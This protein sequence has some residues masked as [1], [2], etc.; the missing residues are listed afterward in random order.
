MAS[1]LLLYSGNLN[2]VNKDGTE[3]ENTLSIVCSSDLNNLARQWAGDFSA[4]HPEIKIEIITADKNDFPGYLNSDKSIGL[5]S[6]Q[7]DEAV[8]E[9]IRWRIIIGREIVVPVINKNNPYLD[10]INEAGISPENL[11][12]LFQSGRKSTWGNLLGNKEEHPV[13]IYMH[14]NGTVLSLV[15]KFTGHPGEQEITEKYTDGKQFAESIANDP[16][17][18]GFCCLN[19]IIESESGNLIDEIR[20]LPIDNNN[21]GRID[22]FESIYTN[23]ADFYR[24]V[25]IG[26]YPKS[27]ISNLY[28]VAASAPSNEAEI[29]FLKWA[30]TDGQHI[31]GLLGFNELASAEKQSGLYKLIDQK[32]FAENTT[33]RLAFLKIILLIVV[34]L[35]GVGVAFNLIIRYRQKKHASMH[36]LQSKQP[37]VINI[38]SLTIPKGLYYDKTHTW[39]FMEEEGIVKIGIDDFLQHITGPFTKLKMKEPGMKVKKNEEILSLV[40]DGKHLSIYAPISGTI[41]LINEDLI[42]DPAIVNASP[43]Q[44]GWLYKIE[45]SNWLREIQ[46]LK[47]AEYHREWLKYEFSRLKDFLARSLSA[48]DSIPVTYQEGGELIDHVLK[49]MNPQIWEDFQKKFIDTSALK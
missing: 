7:Y 23:L 38:G 43:Y 12:R 18:I 13:N 9:S 49:D 32:I 10:K 19:Q 26:K 4:I 37:G 47:M 17:G 25:W 30:V 21:N 44:K 8:G 16:Y 14:S 45:P 41:K 34:V 40:Q 24:G 15:G 1:V 6:G 20:L 5:I 35:I 31:V 11:S 27:L 2:A 3:G 33:D 46:F 48:H 22:H 36:H 39:A 42:T 28:S 29:S